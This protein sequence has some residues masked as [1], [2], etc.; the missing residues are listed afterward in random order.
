MM[1]CGHVMMLMSE[2]TGVVSSQTVNMWS[3]VGC[4]GGSWCGRLRELSSPHSPSRGSPA[5][6]LIVSVSPSKAQPTQL[7]PLSRLHH[8]TWQLY[9]CHIRGSSSDVS[10]TLSYAAQI[11]WKMFLIRFFPVQVGGVGT[12]VLS[13]ESSSQRGSRSSDG[14]QTE[15][16]SSRWISEQKSW[17]RC[18]W[19]WWWEQHH[20]RHTVCHTVTESVQHKFTSRTQVLWNIYLYIFNS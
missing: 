8:L 19:W 5:S 17:R 2:D 4:S 9:L 12:S 15:F 14:A 3:S 6:V 16:M 18:W 11:Q 10:L 20:H 7:G 13:G 1:T